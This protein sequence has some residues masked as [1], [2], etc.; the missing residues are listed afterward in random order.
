MKTFLKFALPPQRN[1]LII[2]AILTIMQTIFQIG[3]IN[4]LEVSLN[5][6]KTENISGV[7]NNGIIMLCFTVILMII[8]IALVIITNNVVTEIGYNTRKKIFHII[9]NVPFEDVNS[10]RHT[11]LISRSVRGPYTEQEFIL[12]LI[13]GLIS[14]PIITIGVIIQLNILNND[15]ATLFT[16]SVLLT[17]II[18]RIKIEKVTEIYFM[19]KKTY[20]RINFLFWEKIRSAKT[21]RIYKKQDFEKKQFT[22]AAENS[23]I[24]S[25]NYLLG[26]YYLAPTIMLFYNLIIVISMIF[27]LN[28][29]HANQLLSYSAV[30]DSL[31]IIQYLIFFTSSLSFVPKFIDIWPK[32]YATSVRMEAVLDLE[33]KMYETENKVK[34]SD[35]KGIEFKNVSYTL[36]NQK[37]LDDISFKIP[38]KS[39]VAIVGETSSGKTTLMYLLDKLYELNEGEILIDGIDINDTYS[40]EVRSKISFAMQANYVLNDTVYNNIIMGDK[41]ITEEDAIIACEKTG[42]DK[43]FIEENKNLNSLIDENGSNISPDFKKKLSLTRAI[44]HDRDIYIFDEHKYIVENKTNIL[45]TKNIEEIKDLDHIIVLEEG[46]LAGIGNHQE[47]IK[48]CLSYQNLFERGG[49]NEI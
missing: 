41:T 31:I 16:I 39:T 43:L 9:N 12:F 33:H 10:I 45:L 8:L 1:K 18:L 2:I 22:E 24:K 29:Y 32:S 4:Y 44:A 47:L 36:N 49:Y 14:A 23:F 3:I 37:I 42:L 20:G 7:L 17:V 35:F 28:N 48:N 5:C 19:A 30:T 6:I 40:K 13:R 15:F 11:G 46:R 34:K 38:S 27:L 25:I 21:I 26:Q